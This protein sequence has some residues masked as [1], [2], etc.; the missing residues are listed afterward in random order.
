MGRALE[1]EAGKRISGRFFEGGFCQTMRNDV[2][3]PSVLREG[4]LAVRGEWLAGLF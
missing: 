1:L 4:F 3:F 2:A